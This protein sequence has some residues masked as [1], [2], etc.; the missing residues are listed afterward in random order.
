M[1][2]N[3]EKLLRMTADYH[4]FCSDEHLQEK[5]KGMDEMSMD[6]LDFVAAATGFNREI[7]DHLKNQD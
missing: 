7:P 5:D 6:E 1:S 4:R 2:M 3:I